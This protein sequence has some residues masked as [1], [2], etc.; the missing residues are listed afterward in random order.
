[1]GRNERERQLAYR[2]HLLSEQER[3]EED[4]ACFGG[5]SLAV[6]DDVFLTRTAKVCGRLSPRHRGRPKSPPKKM[7]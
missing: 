7:S 5:T 1:M 3:W 4:A 2:R 6:G